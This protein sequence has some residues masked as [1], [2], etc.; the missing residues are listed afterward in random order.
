MRN[1]IAALRSFLQPSTQFCAV[2]KANAY[3]H[4]IREVAKICSEEGVRLFAV[5]NIDEA[6]TVH[7]LFPQAT[8]FI[9]G[10][11]PPE[12]LYDAVSTGAIQVVYDV[13]TILELTKHASR[14]HKPARLSLKIET[15]LHR[16]GTTLRGLENLLDTIRRAGDLVSVESVATHFAS[17][18]EIENPMNTYQVQQFIA[19]LH[20]IQRYGYQPEFQHLA[21]SAAGMASPEAQGTMVRFGIALYGL[22]P[23]KE[24]KRHVILGRQ[25]VEL[26]PVLQWKT[27]IA[28][29]KDVSAGSAVGYGGKFVA[30]RPMRIAILPVGYYDGYDRALSQ[31]GEVLIRGRRCAVLGV[32]CMNMMIVDVSAVPAVANHDEVT[33]LGRD[34]M[35]ILTADDMATAIGTIHY[36]VVTRLNP[37]TQRI[38]VD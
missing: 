27:C 10:Y 2:I 17:A 28:Q 22:W 8:V 16:Q 14:L 9:L 33:L 26:T 38:I 36:E 29:I 34:G 23:S 1:N 12:R 24:I 35:H 6:M 37:L 31:K 7:E 4:G 13:E 18:E 32:I 15:G 3:G 25:N 20:I 19:A 11:T 21:C 5:D 30:N